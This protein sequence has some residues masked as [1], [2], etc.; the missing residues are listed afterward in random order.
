MICWYCFGIWAWLRWWSEAWV[1]AQRKQIQTKFTKGVS[2][3]TQGWLELDAFC[4]IFC[5]FFCGVMGRVL[6][7]AVPN[8]GYSET[9]LQTCRRKGGILK[10]VVSWTRNTIFGRFEGLVQDKK[11]SDRFQALECSPVCTTLFCPATEWLPESWSVMA[12]TTETK[13]QE[14]NTRIWE[15][16]RNKPLPA[17][18]VIQASA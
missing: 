8:G 13:Q 9:L 11:W 14:C 18:D 2:K 6:L 12:C 4:C 1:R 16:Y 17:S 15:R 3:R 5:W 7:A 10:T